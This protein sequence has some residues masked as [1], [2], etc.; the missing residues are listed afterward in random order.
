MPE[1]VIIARVPSGIY[2]ISKPVGHIYD[3]R[4]KDEKIHFL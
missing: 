1:Y 3:L 2:L 4:V